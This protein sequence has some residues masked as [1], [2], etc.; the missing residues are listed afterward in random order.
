M[1]SS[2]L[3]RVAQY[4]M[5]KLGHFGTFW[6]ICSDDFTILP[7]TAIY[8]VKRQNAELGHFG[9]EIVMLY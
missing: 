9:T 1:A 5:L 4:Q 6:D 7:T 3:W 8:E 2:R